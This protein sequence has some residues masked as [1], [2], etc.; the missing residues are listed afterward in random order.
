MR[1]EHL[2]DFMQTFRHTGLT[3][4][5]VSLV[6]QYADFL[7]DQADISSS[8]SRNIKL[9]V[10][11]ISAAMDTVTESEMAIAMARL[12][13][14]GV[15]HK[16]LS[17]EEQADE[18][19]TVK[20][21]LNGFISNP[22]VF[23]S[24]QTVGEMLDIKEKKKYSFSGFPI[25]DNN[26]ILVGIVTSRD[27]KFLTDYTVKIKDV[28]TKNLVTAPDGT[29]LPE[30]FAVMTKYKVGKLPTVD[31]NGKLTGLYSFHDVKT[32][33]ENIEPFYNRD[34]NH[35]LRVAAAV[36]PYDEKRAALLVE[37]GVDAMIID[38]AHGHSK[39][40]IETVKMMK[41]KYGSLV[42]VVAGNIAS[43][44]AAKALLEAGADAVKVGIGPGSICTTRVVAGVGTPQLTAVYECRKAVGDEIPVIADG[45]IK[46]S[47]DVAKAIASGAY[48]VMMRSALA[49]P[50]ES[51]GEKIVHH[52]RRYVVYRG[53]GSLEAMKTA[54]GSRERY[55]QADVD[56]TKKLVPQG[57]E[58]MVPYR[59]A[60]WEVIHQFS[61]G[62]KYSLGYCG[63]RTVPEFQRTSKFIR[64]TNAGLKEAHPHDITMLKDAP[65][66]MAD[67]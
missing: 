21:Y 34:K 60:L 14:I 13:G 2:D 46:Q 29:Q 50:L 51:L 22:V 6:V 42:D 48:C 12:G 25:V 1:N 5:D 53:M 67:N 3:F 59:G 61:G 44:D 10:P 47:G 49:G 64:V 30:A 28:M 33:T 32:L 8:F 35:R 43:G 17:A 62:L 26:G 37:A 41:S 9:N 63:A 40:V 54:R 7:P 55:G 45:G 19:R 38:T 15:I 31:K 27:V 4:D 39:G 11:F 36:G 20:Q 65:N 16:N 52:G 57:I 18:V 56:D 66:Y 24:E 58:G 23:N